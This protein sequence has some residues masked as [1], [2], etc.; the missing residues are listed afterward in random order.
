METVL[1]EI[2]HE[3][4]DRVQLAHNNVHWRVAVIMVINFL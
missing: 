1:M 4:V 3:D 2:V